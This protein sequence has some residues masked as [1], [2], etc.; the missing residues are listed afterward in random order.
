[1]TYKVFSVD[2]QVKKSYL[3]G[4]FCNSK[5]KMFLFV[6][7][8]MNGNDISNFYIKEEETNNVISL[9]AFA[10]HYGITKEDIKQV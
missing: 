7:Y 1:M 2:E 3:W 6:S 8:L 10:A 4:T 5:E 9:S